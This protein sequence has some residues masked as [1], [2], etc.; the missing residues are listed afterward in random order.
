MLQSS[1]APFRSI[2]VI[3]TKFIGD[4]VLASALAQNLRLEFPGAR[5]VFLCEARFES[6]V[7]AH[8]IASEVVTFRRARMRAAPWSVGKSFTPW[9]G[10]CAATALT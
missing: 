2:L 8:G 6:F 7:I 4:L 3:Q 9:C 1:P 10:R 5:L